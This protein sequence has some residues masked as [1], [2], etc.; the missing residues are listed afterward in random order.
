MKPTPLIII[1]LVLAGCNP[2]ADTL[3]LKIEALSP[4]GKFE[5]RLVHREVGEPYSENWVV[6]I[7][8]PKAAITGWGE[9]VSLEFPMDYRIQKL[10]WIDSQRLEIEYEKGTSELNLRDFRTPLHG[11]TIILKEK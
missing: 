3:K 9:D 4:D 7:A 11:I 6:L 10:L 2:F 8:N 5:A 1:C